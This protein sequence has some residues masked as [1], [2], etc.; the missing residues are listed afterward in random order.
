[1]YSRFK[2]QL[3]VRGARCAGALLLL[4]ASLITPTAAQS[5]KAYQ[6]QTIAISAGCL[7]CSEVNL[8]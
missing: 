2:R 5:H 6:P 7:I 1:M 4:S 3:L 8:S